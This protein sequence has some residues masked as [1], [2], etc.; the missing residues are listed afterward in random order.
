MCL[1][2]I[3]RIPW[4]PLPLLSCSSRYPSVGLAQF[5]AFVVGLQDL[6][7][8]QTRSRH[9]KGSNLAQP[10]S[11]PPAAAVEGEA[12]HQTFRIVGASD[13]EKGIFE[14]QRDPGPVPVENS[15]PVAP[16]HANPYRPARISQAGRFEV[17]KL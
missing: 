8:A 14:P 9:A 7:E 4:I 15:G 5:D 6:F 12:F 16:G 3:P 10:H 11:M 2:W 1:F 13:S 17:P